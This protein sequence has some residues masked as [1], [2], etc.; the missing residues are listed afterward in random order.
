[1]SDIGAI[2][3]RFQHRVRA[4]FVYLEEAHAQD[5]WPVGHPYKYLQTK[6][7]ESRLSVFQDFISAYGVAAWP[8]TLLIDRTDNAFH[9]A[10]A[11]WP[12]RFYV[13][14]GGIMRFIAY[15]DDARYTLQPLLEWLDATM[16]P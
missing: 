8:I 12:V 2:I 4:A 5:E 16:P 10:Y 7:L 11:S 3:S 15:P 14:Q 6:T 13:I 1:M 9:N